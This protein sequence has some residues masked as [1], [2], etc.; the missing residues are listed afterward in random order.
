MKKTED[1]PATHQVICIDHAYYDDEFVAFTGTQEEC[2]NY[3]ER[4]FTEE[5]ARLGLCSYIIYPVPAVTKAICFLTGEAMDK[6][7]ILVLLWN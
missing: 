1:I 3:I 7:E 2:N 5:D 4:H 6:G